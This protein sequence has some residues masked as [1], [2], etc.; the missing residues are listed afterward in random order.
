MS[1]YTNTSVG[2]DQ[3]ATPSGDVTRPA[4]V[5]LGGRSR[6]LSATAFAGA[7]LAF[8][9]PFGTVASCG[10]E[11]V[12]F[13]GA[14]LVTFDVQPDPSTSHGTLHDDVE[15]NA[16]LFGLV[17]LLA[18]AAGLVTAIQG[19]RRGGTCASVALVAAQLLGLGILFSATGDVMLHRGF[20]LMF[21][22]LAVAGVVHLAAR[23]RERRDAGRP[24][25]GYAI[26]RCSI[27][28]SPTLGIIALIAV[29]AAGG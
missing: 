26:A 3:L 19:V 4:R 7:A 18:A 9:L 10:G 14:E 22:G 20:V 1:E 27:A 25:W 5:G 24:F 15:R 29:L 21:T 6:I 8:T 28:L 16:G 23:I 2:R 12:R 11:E 17:I 13:T